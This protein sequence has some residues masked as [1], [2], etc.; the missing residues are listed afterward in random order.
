MY[1]VDFT[2]KKIELEM[3]AAAQQVIGNLLLAVQMEGGVG[4]V[5]PGGISYKLE[6]HDWEEKEEADIQK[7]IDAG[8]PAKHNLPWSAKDYADLSERFRSDH[9]TTIDSLAREFERTPVSIKYQLQKMGLIDSCGEA[10]GHNR[11]TGEPRKKYIYGT[12]YSGTMK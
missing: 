4:L 1:I 11:N 6:A 9:S 3:D 8:H 5:L 12:P 7:N 2:G 10:I